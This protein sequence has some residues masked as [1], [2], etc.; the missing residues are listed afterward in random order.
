LTNT[1]IKAIKSACNDEIAKIC[2]NDETV[3]IAIKTYLTSADY[4]NIQREWIEEFYNQFYT[5]APSD[6]FVIGNLSPK[7]VEKIEAIFESYPPLKNAPKDS[8]LYQFSPQLEE[9]IVIKKENS[10]QAAINIGCQLFSRKHPDF[11]KFTLLNTVLGGYFGSRLMSNI[12][13]EKG[14]TYGIQSS[15][16]TN[17]ETGH[18]QISTQTANEYIDNVIAE[19]YKELKLLCEEPIPNDELNIVKNYMI[20]SMARTLDGDFSRAGFYI[21]VN[22]YGMDIEEYVNTKLEVINSTTSDEL[23][24]LA[25]KYF[26]SKKMHQVIVG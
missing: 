1:Q 18:M 21:S 8:S 17:L 3:E 2:I 26:G 20:G 7:E 9:E 14:Y 13:E 23:K 10:V 19:I 24:S 15:V 25:Q 11:H 16:Y 6:V 4:E 22:N 5:I 12:R